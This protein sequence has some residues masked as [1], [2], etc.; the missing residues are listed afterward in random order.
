MRPFA[1]RAP[2]LR[3]PEPAAVFLLFSFDASSTAVRRRN[4]LHSFCKNRILERPRIRTRIPRHHI[5]DE[6]QH[7]DLHIDRIRQQLPVT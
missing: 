2:A 7:L 3:T 6:A 5:G 1:A 4:Q